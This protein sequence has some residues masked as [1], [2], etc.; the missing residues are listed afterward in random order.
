MSKI[1]KDVVNELHAP[2]RRN[3]KRRRVIL[4]GWRDLYQADL[5]EMI[6]YSK[7]NKGFKYILMVIDAFSKF[8]WAV[9]LKNKSGK[10]V[11]RAMQTILK[12][13]QLIP[14]NIQT[15]HGKEFYN[16][17]FKN[18]MKQHNINHY[19]S[20]STLK[21]SIVE[22][23]NRTIKEKMW[24]EFS[25]QGTYKWLDLLPLIIK[26]YNNT[27]H[28]TIGMKPKDVNSRNAK[29]LLKTVYGSLKVIDR[30]PRKFNVGDHVRISKHR[31]AF[32]K[33][34][35]ANFTNEIFKISKVQNTMPRTYLLQDIQGENIIGGFYEA[36]LKKVAHP[37][38][39]LVEKVIRRKGDKV[40]VKFLGL[41]KSHN[42][43]I[44]KKN[45]L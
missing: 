3:F 16:A 30:R 40:L 32:T 36:E 2:A 6:P 42:S 14:K 11:T 44:S 5:V 28:R 26:N 18:L 25:L 10:E 22:R 4:K 35:T 12:N 19:S 1:K 15:D 33:N 24:K 13:K 45:V 7:E 38:V 8:G 23:F 29:L 41:D 20:Y 34:Y 9:P 39:Y 21:S 37:D 43:W 31:H 17:D 27:I